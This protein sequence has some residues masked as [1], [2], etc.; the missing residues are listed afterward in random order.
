NPQ[1]IVRALDVWMQTGQPF[2][3]F[4]SNG[5]VSPPEDLLVIG[6]RRDRQSLYERINRRVDQM[7]EK[8]FLDEVRSIL[9]RGYAL[10]D[11]GLNTVGYKQAIAFLNGELSRDEMINQIKVKTRRY[12]KR[13]LTYFRRWDFIN[14]LEIDDQ[15]A[16]ET[17][18]QIESML[19]KKA[20]NSFI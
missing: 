1:R 14:W 16:S 7:F 19:A 4:H 10:S 12:A 2:S 13:Q 6:L 9:E 18:K 15:S 3:S 8:G 20:N 5:T 11:P 17:A